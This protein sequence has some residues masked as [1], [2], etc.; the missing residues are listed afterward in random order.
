[1]A[2]IRK[3]GKS[4]QIRAS[5]GYDS[6]GQQIV[7]AMTWTPPDSLTP[8]QLEKELNR[9]TVDFERRV[10][11]GQCIDSNIRFSEYAELWIKRGEAEG[12]KPLA[13]K[14][15]DRY[16]ALLVRINAAIGHIKLCDLQ[17]HHIREFLDNLKEEGIRE[18]ITYTPAVDFPALLKKRKLTRP[19]LA[20][21]AHL[22]DSTVYAAC[23]GGSVSKS[24]AESMCSV[25]N[26]K[27]KDSFTPN[28]TDGGKLSDKTVLHHYRLISTILNS[29]VVDDQALLSNPAK[30]VRP[31]HCERVEAQYLDE[32]QAAHMI[33]LLSK[34]PMQYKT[35]VLLLLYTGMRRGELCG[36]EWKDIDLDN[37]TLSIC[38][39]SQ[40]TPEKG[41]F[42][43]GTKTASSVRTI[44]L[45]EIAVNLL[46]KYRTWQ[47]EQRLAVGDQWEDNDRLYT[48]WNGKPAHPD[49]LTSWFEDFINRTDLPKI[50]IHS[51]RHTNATL[52]IAGGEDIR[53][54]S[55]R[56]GHAQ[57]TTT[58]NTYTH[59][60][61][62][63]DAKAAET[64]ENILDPMKKR[65]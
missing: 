12:E 60:I 2:T 47:I 3:R 63:A 42:V 61:Q 57:V 58:V 46:R 28:E 21:T 56:L 7:K 4:Y 38:R 15:M 10:E 11:N 64:L 14:T 29:A 18:D 6:T 50:H 34:E 19:A 8:K 55:R 30:R 24:T 9:I 51:L 40:Y 65:A 53:T 62:S 33:E 36:L 49:T 22:A 41:I 13:P 52:M 16:K 37:R 31:P 32:V 54:V 45:P 27:L 17:P 26:L 23:R 1:M 20:K 39:T 35:M 43:K 5:A 25:L 44:K 48:S 59:A